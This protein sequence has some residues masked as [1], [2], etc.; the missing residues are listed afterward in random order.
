V[1]LDHAGGAGAMMQAFPQATLAVHPRGARHMADPAQLVAG[2]RAV[3]GEVTARRLYGEIPPIDAS[4]I[5]AMAH[6]SRISLA[7]REL[8]VLDTPGHARHH[9][10]IVDSGSGHIFTGDTF[11][12][13]YRELDVGDRQS[14]FPSSAPVQFDPEAFHRTLEM[15]AGYKPEAVYVTHYSQVR[16]IARLMGDMHRLID[17]H[18]EIALRHRDDGPGR[19]E[20]IEQDLM[21][22]VY[23]VGDRQGWPVGREELRGLLGPDIQLNATGLESW[24]DAKSRASGG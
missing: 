17:A 15:L 8:L 18:A 3:Y 5:Q 12:L 24:L 13:S 6:E 21:A 4:R 10:C 23:A 16:D 19:G 1:H 11:G 7:G 9:I 22:L 2:T 20:A 14:V